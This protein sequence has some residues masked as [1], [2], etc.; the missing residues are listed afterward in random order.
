MRPFRTFVQK[1]VD[2][3]RDWHVVDAAEFTL[4]RLATVVS[5]LLVG[6]HK[7]SYTPHVDGGD[8]VVVI[9]ADQVRLSGDK[10]RA[11][12]Y[13]RHSGYVGNLKSRTAAQQRQ[14]SS[15]KLI[16]MA[17]R[18]MLPKNKLRLLRLRRLKVYAGADHPHAGQK[19][20]NYQPQTV[21][22]TKPSKETK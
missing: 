14:R 10:E 2:V 20:Q 17:V 22:E 13:Y 3:S 5:A 21:S 6:K 7:P 4:G 8:W 12:T 19:P 1:P 16:Q 15:P 18:G 9:N 11:K